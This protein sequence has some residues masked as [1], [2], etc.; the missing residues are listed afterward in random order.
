[1]KEQSN[2]ATLINEQ[3]SICEK[4]GAAFMDAPLNLKVGISE[5][6]K[7]GIQPING[8]R[9]F[10]KG[11]TTGWYIWAGEYSDSPDFFKPLHVEHLDKWSSLIKPFLGLEPGYRFLIAENGNYVDVWEDLSLLDIVE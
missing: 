10:P 9:H 4:Y 6:V 3:K 8:L 11:D 1:M 7:E 5:S 2:E